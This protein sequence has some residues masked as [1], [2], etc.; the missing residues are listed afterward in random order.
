V[1]R[2]AAGDRDQ[3]VQ[4]CVSALRDRLGDTEQRLIVTDG[5]GYRLVVTTPIVV[6]I[7]W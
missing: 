6:I 2:R 7:W 1:G 3:Q 5:S 4:N